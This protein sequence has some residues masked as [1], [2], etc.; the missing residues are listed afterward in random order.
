MPFINHLCQDIFFTL[1]C[2]RRTCC[3]EFTFLFSWGLEQMRILL[4]WLV[5]ATTSWQQ[6]LLLGLH[7]SC[8]P[9]GHSRGGGEGNCQAPSIRLALKMRLAQIQSFL[10]GSVGEVAAGREEKK[11]KGWCL[12][13]SLQA[14]LKN[15]CFP[16][17]PISP[18]QKLTLSLS[19]LASHY[20]WPHIMPACL[21]S[22]LRAKFWRL[23]QAC[24][25][26]KKNE[27]MNYWGN[28]IQS[29]PNREKDILKAK[30]MMGMITLSIKGARDGFVNYRNR[31]HHHN[32]R[33]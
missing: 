21:N 1:S 2:I 3:L 12:R 33:M 14:F 9:Q 16:G 7:F 25:C 22:H 19:A 15:L 11:R 30:L 5:L 4:C 8:Q 29:Q 31:P 27:W 26:C 17:P 6:E 10:S 32:I 23:L 20:Y 28:R 13:E 24:L 18:S